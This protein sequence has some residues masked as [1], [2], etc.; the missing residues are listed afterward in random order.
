MSLTQTEASP[1][2]PEDN[3]TDVDSE[4]ACASKVAEKSVEIF[5]SAISPFRYSGSGSRASG[6]CAPLKDPFKG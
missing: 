4:S 1:S 3:S 2:T 5:V 6:L